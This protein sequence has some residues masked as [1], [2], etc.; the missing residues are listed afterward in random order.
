MRGEKDQESHLEAGLTLS[1]SYTLEFPQDQADSPSCT[2]PCAWLFPLSSPAS[3]SLFPD[4][5][6]GI[7]IIY[8]LCMNPQHR[9]IL[10]EP[11]L[12]HG[13]LC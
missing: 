2:P 10:E 11:S 5:Q 8:Y 9:V 7:L 12:R 1:V 3:P 13:L 6:V 4:S